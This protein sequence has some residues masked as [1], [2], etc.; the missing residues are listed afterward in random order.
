MQREWTVSGEDSFIDLSIITS[1]YQSEDYVAEFYNR[2]KLSLDSAE[3]RFEVIF[4][5]DGY[6]DK[7][8][9]IAIEL[10]LENKEIIV[11]LLSRN[12]G[13]NAALLAGLSYAR[14]DRIAFIDCD[15][16]EKPELILEIYRIFGERVNEIDLIYAVQKNREGPLAR[17]LGGSLFYWVMQFISDIDIKANS[18]VLRIMSRRYAEALKQFKENNFSLGGICA[19][20]GFEQIPFEAEKNYK[21]KS[22]YS[23]KK[24][25]FAA[26]HFLISYSTRPAFIFLGFGL[27]VMLVDFIGVGWLLIRK[28]FFGVA[29]EGWTSLA[30]L[31]LFVI[32]FLFINNG[33]LLLYLLE[34]FNNTK[35]RPLW[36]VKDVFRGR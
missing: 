18:M 28:L 21:G 16:E 19:L 8:A 10:G 5:D 1:L 17:R 36:V 32:G 23:I 35:R 30:V 12:F 13:Q 24:R 20:A 29:V 3:I 22:S 2:L 11:V 31:I 15:L 25:V 6:K 4:V 26:T 33:V 34:T 9:E 14:G 27:L 7:A